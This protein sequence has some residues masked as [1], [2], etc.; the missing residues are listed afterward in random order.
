MNYPGYQAPLQGMANQ[1]AQYGRY[2]DS[3]LVH[4]NP[5]EVQGIAALSPT[6]QLTTN[7]VTGQPEAFLPFLAPILGSMLGSSL[8]TGAGAGILGTTF[9]GLSPAMA[10]AIGSGLAT[11]AV[12]GDLKEGLISGIT[13]Y[14]LGH[15]FE[16]AAK[17]LDPRIAA[18]EGALETVSES[19]AKGAADVAGKEALAQAAGADVAAKEA[20]LRTLGQTPIT[21]AEAGSGVSDILAAGRDLGQ[22]QRFSSTLGKDLAE[23][24]QA[25]KAL[26]GGESALESSLSNLRGNISRT[27][28]LTAPFRQP[29]ALL[30]GLTDPRAILPIAVGEGTRGQYQMQERLQDQR[31]E[32]MGETEEEKARALYNFQE[33]LAQREQDYGPF[34]RYA[35]G[36]ITSINPENYRQ[37]MEGLQRLA[38]MPVQMYSGGYLGGSTAGSTGAGARQAS[39]RPPSVV[40]PPEEYRPGFDPEFVYFQDAPR[41]PPST[42]GTA[43]GGTAPGGAAPATGGPSPEARGLPVQEMGGV[44]Q[45]L[46]DQYTRLATTQGN[47]HRQSDLSGKNIANRDKYLSQFMTMRA[48][49][50]ELMKLDNALDIDPAYRAGG[51][52]AYSDV[53]G[54]AF[55]DVEGTTP[56]QTPFQA[57]TSSAVQGAISSRMP[58]FE[59][60]VEAR[61]LPAQQRMTPARG[62]QIRLGGMAPQVSGIPDLTTTPVGIGAMAAPVSAPQTPGVGMTA[63]QQPSPMLSGRGFSGGAVGPTPVTPPAPVAPPPAAPSQ[64]V[65]AGGSPATTT[66]PIFNPGM[67][68]NLD[69]TQL[70]GIDAEGIGAMRSVAPRAMAPAPAA[71][72]ARTMDDKLEMLRSRGRGMT[73]GRMAQRFQEGGEVEIEIEM[74][75]DEMEDTMEANGSRLIEQTAAAIAG[76]MPE[77]QAEAI[78]NRFIDEYGP[79]AFEMLRERVLQDIVPGAQTEGRIEGQGGGMDDMIPG[80]IGTQQPVAVS[81]GEYIVPA[82]VVSGLGD[83]DTDAGASELDGMLDRVRQAR[84]GRRMQPQPLQKDKVMPA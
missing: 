10:G 22:A 36:G 73:D 46:I 17:A 50:P 83:G 33:A 38:G 1:M 75:G 27:D 64:P 37:N 13:G 60:D 35:A 72:P 26:Q 71:A 82:D 21:P 41:P 32:L 19:A 61:G 57:A 62:G 28:R 48:Q 6:G 3:M 2:G 58:T 69:M 24:Q 18:T 12:T 4:M 20:A 16:G 53:V 30:K 39:I 68:F 14:G 31:R 40:A 66:S 42:G 59:A 11:T 65:F 67:G 80:M 52:E 25:L 84:T 79:E 44:N 34:R 8:L 77:D 23:A 63:T 70:P 56:T 76:N 7:P 74:G 45:S 49:Y 43:P 54:N 29:G 15:M 9:A 51:S 5:I 81:P 55:G 47:F 78:I